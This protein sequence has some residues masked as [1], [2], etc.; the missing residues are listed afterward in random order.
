V[1]YD[2]SAGYS[3]HQFNTNFTITNYE[4][5]S[6][7]TPVSD[8]REA[9]GQSVHISWLANDW[10]SNYTALLSLYFSNSSGLYL[11]D[12]FP[13]VVNDLYYNYYLNETLDLGSYMF[14]FIPDPVFE[15][16][17]T[18]SLNSTVFELVAHTILSYGSLGESNSYVY[19]STALVTWSLT[20]DWHTGEMIQLDLYRYYNSST[21][22]LIPEVSKTVEALDGLVSISLSNAPVGEHFWRISGVNDS[23]SGFTLDSDHF[24]IIPG[25]N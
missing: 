22:T 14:Q 6:F 16:A 11:I 2:L 5:D 12:S 4:I 23:L 17:Y 3:G 21:S 18:G 8:S 1:E 9:R 7:V 24:H 20:S 15:D 10:P 13:A 25:K 19:N